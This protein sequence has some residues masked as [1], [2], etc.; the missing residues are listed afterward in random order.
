MSGLKKIFLLLVLLFAA[1]NLAY[2]AVV[3]IADTPFSS[4][5]LSSGTGGD[6]PHIS[7]GVGGVNCASDAVNS[8]AECNTFLGIDDAQATP[9]DGN[10]YNCSCPAAYSETCTIGAGLPCK[11]KFKSCSQEQSCS[12]VIDSYYGAGTEVKDEGECRT[13]QGTEYYKSPLCT[14]SAGDIKA[15]CIFP[16]CTDLQTNTWREYN[17]P[18]QPDVI[19][20]GGV[21]STGS[22][23]KDGV[24]Y[25]PWFCD[26]T[27]YTTEEEPT[28]PEMS[29]T[30]SCTL[31]KKTKYKP[32]CVI[33]TCDAVKADAQFNGHGVVVTTET[34]CKANQGRSFW[35]AIECM[36]GS[37]K[38][39]FCAYPKCDN[40]LIES[41]TFTATAIDADKTASGGVVEGR[42]VDGNTDKY[43]WY[44]QTNYSELPPQSCTNPQM[45]PVECPLEKVLKYKNECEFPLCEETD[46]TINNNV[47]A[48][49]VCPDGTTNDFSCR[50]KAADTTAL[51]VCQCNTEIYPFSPEE[52]CD[53]AEEKDPADTR[54][55]MPVR[56]MKTNSLTNP[57]TTSYCEWD[58]QTALNRDTG[59]T[60]TYE[61]KKIRYKRCLPA[62]PVEAAGKLSYMK[63]TCSDGTVLVNCAAGNQAGISAYYCACPKDFDGNDLYHTTCPT[64]TYGG[65]RTCQ[66]G[67]NVKKFE[68]CLPKCD[69]SAPR[70]IADN[71]TEDK[72]EGIAQ[73]SAGDSLG[74][75]V[76][77][78]KSGDAYTSASVCNYETNMYC[79]KKDTTLDSSSC[80]QEFVALSDNGEFS[81]S[82][83][84]ASSTN[85]DKQ[86]CIISSGK[87]AASWQCG[88]YQYYTDEEC[89]EIYGADYRGAGKKC[90]FDLADDGT[91]AVVK[92]ESC[93]LPCPG[94]PYTLKPTSE[95]CNLT[96]STTTYT[97]KAEACFDVESAGQK[98]VC[99]CPD[100]FITLN[101]YCAENHSGDD[102]CLDKYIGQGVACEYDLADA[103]ENT[104]PVKLKKYF[105]NNFGELCLPGIKTET[106]PAT[107]STVCNFGT[108]TN[109]YE[110]CYDTKG[111][112]KAGCKCPAS[113]KTV[114]EH[115]KE[116]NAEQED[117]DKCIAET[118]G[119]GVV[120]E[121]DAVNPYQ[122]GSGFLKKYSSFAPYC[123]ESTERPVS[124][125]ET[126]TLNGQELSAKGSKCYRKGNTTKPYYL[127][128]CPASYISECTE[129]DSGLIPAGKV[130]TF[131]S[132]TS[133]KYEGCFKQCSN[134]ALTPVVGTSD[135]CPM[136][137]GVNADTEE[138][139][140]K[141][142]DTAASYACRCPASQNYKTL[143]R[144]CQ[145]IAPAAD[146]SQEAATARCLN[147]YVGVG[148]PCTFDID[149]NGVSVDKYKSFDR[150]CPTDRP[151]FYTKEECTGGSV[152]GVYEGTCHVKAGD[153]QERV[154][155]TCPTS[156]VTACT[157]G[158]AGTDADGNP[159]STQIPDPDKEPSGQICNFEGDTRIK[160]QGCYT[161]C[162][163]I[164]SKGV[165]YMSD[166][167]ASAV[168][169]TNSLGDGAYFGVNNT[170]EQCS[171]NHVLSNPCYC[172]DTFVACETTKNQRPADN[173][174]ACTISGET[175]YSECSNN[176]CETESPTLAWIEGITE[177]DDRTADA[178]CQASY[179]SGAVGKKCGENKV[180]CT[181]NAR[182][183]T[184]TCDYPYDK[185]D[186]SKVQWC[187]YSTSGGLMK[188]G[189]D[190][191]KLGECKVKP[192]MALCG[193]HILDSSGN[194]QTG[195]TINI[196]STEGQ[197][198][199]QYGPGAKTQLCEYE[200]DSNKRA[201]NCYYNPSDFTFTE[202]NCP[203]RHVLDGG[204]VVKNGTKY[205]ANCNCH[206]AYK[207]HKF[208]CAGMLSGGACTQQ[209]TASMVGNDDSLAGQVGNSLAFYPYCQCT[210]DYKFECDGERNVGVGTACNGKYTECKCQPDELPENWADNYYGCPGGK[211]P[212]GV[213]KPNGCGG[214]YYQCTVTQCTW[215]HTQKCESP[216]IG[217]DPCQDNLGNIGGYKSC[218]CPSGYN[219]CAEGKVGQGEPC[220]LNGQYYY[221]S[222]GDSAECVHGE[223]KTCLGEFQVGVNPCVKNGITYFQY[224]TC[225]QGYDKLCSDEAKVGEGASCK[226]DGK[227]YYSKC[228]AP[229][230]SCTAE[231]KEA[232]DS[233]QEKYDPCVNSDMK[234]MYKCK[235]PTNYKSCPNG[236]ADGTPSC[237]DSNGTVYA[238]CAVSNT[239]NYEQ[240]KN[241]KVCTS[242]QKGVGGSCVDSIVDSS[243]N[244]TDIIKYADCEDTDQC[245]VN[246][247]QYTCMGYDQSN[248]GD[249]FCTDDKGNRLYKECKC[250]TDWI[251][252]PG[253]NNTKG[254]ACTPQLENGST[255]TTV[256]KS[257]TCDEFRF[258]Y[259]CAASETGNKGVIP[260]SSKSCQPRTYKD[261]TEYGYEEGSTLYESCDCTAGYTQTCKGNGQVGNESDYCE[262]VPGSGNK[263]YKSC[264]CDSKYS[265]TC[266]LDAS[267]PGMS[268]PA[269]PLKACIAVDD[270][271]VEAAPKYTACECGKYYDLTCSDG[272]T[273]GSDTDFC[274][275]ADGAVDKTYYRKCSCNPDIYV[276]TCSAETNGKGAEVSKVGTD[277]VCVEKLSA[278]NGLGDQGAI[279]K[280][281][282]S[283]CTCKTNYKYSCVKGVSN[284]N[285]AVLN[286]NGY[287]SETFNEES[288][289]ENKYA[290]PSDEFCSKTTGGN[291]FYQ[292][293]SCKD[294][295][296]YK[297]CN[298]GSG[299]TE[300]HA[301]KA[302][303]VNNY[304]LAV[305]ANGNVSKMYRE[306]DCQCKPKDLTAEELAVSPAW[307][308]TTLIS[309]V[310]Q[311]NNGIFR[312]MVAEKCKDRDNFDLL[313]KGCNTIY[314]RCVF[315]PNV[316]PYSQSN[317][318]SLAPSGSAQYVPQGD[319]DTKTTKIGSL[320]MY[321][322]C[323]CDASYKFTESGSTSCEKFYEASSTGD[324]G[325]SVGCQ[326]QT[327]DTSWI[328]TGCTTAGIDNE[329]KPAISLVVLDESSLCIT[330]ETH[331]KKYSRCK[332]RPAGT[333]HGNACFTYQY[334][335]EG[336]DMI[337]ITY[338][339]K[340]DEPNTRYPETIYYNGGKA[341]NDCQCKI[342][343][344]TSKTQQ[345]G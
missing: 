237:T 315:D 234:I 142:G 19:A 123:P 81:S 192:V 23:W 327:S 236:A 37:T 215:Q 266:A 289:T 145:T 258:R 180:Q 134:T 200:N 58:Y 333:R 254:T 45:R 320:T 179:G 277:D 291:K 210:A 155:C 284:L 152:K 323:D 311:Y 141:T 328:Y 166:D 153:T 16:L 66:E 309:D 149:T 295:Y 101:Q 54:V 297:D 62:C 336:D 345:C 7:T 173:A 29:T 88:C 246:G 280:E 104:T 11:G 48:S 249:D 319:K 199:S 298:F 209:V 242:S 162:D 222:C 271:G 80:T 334:V 95:A 171:K 44:C 170:G 214:K 70:K 106:I 136:V 133:P 245:R 160:Y 211:Q 40:E 261:G 196:T 94:A 137:N 331:E 3:N 5:S 232:C 201:F 322:K 287:T 290:F 285:N 79:C 229:S 42:C 83:T 151:L 314:F 223:T 278:G 75:W 294:E 12:D 124:E 55:W 109:N 193:K 28:C 30:E 63:Q 318:P 203:V 1:A 31:E 293:C 212:T 61:S 32:A 135:A 241:Y 89:S 4:R 176:K 102:K 24:R 8:P 148:T 161:K 119:E 73:G 103:P 172:D 154:L 321:K 256:Y 338:T 205:Y 64:G 98:Y 67:G 262:K 281:Y 156:Y 46:R 190:H 308:Q 138:C 270:G 97:A 132:L 120:C 292:S 27:V 213:T 183:F 194:Q 310:S 276:E 68:F 279:R 17:N 34:A 41:K 163:T 302:D 57:D 329:N 274:K 337:C 50:L 343:K 226:L 243:G 233:N 127:C 59:K 147:E 181:C 47:P 10:K 144:F 35:K 268:A 304:C 14:N 221:Q 82:C 158:S 110:S 197:C 146:E 195:Y 265:L 224:C 91:T 189:V 99:H 227:E 128:S 52:G 21:M 344:M 105:R 86:L 140:L 15:A 253:K 77:A 252:C 39:V 131:E 9:C 267:N 51:K 2:A 107:G 90:E 288:Y 231:H 228:V 240:K 49:S 235:C 257:C 325:E 22:C 78:T 283:G 251:P 326:K 185:P 191:F 18:S 342:G 255:G 330:R 114:E 247:Y 317:C 216:L 182:E 167:D 299:S 260:A 230:N 207:Q 112:L 25:A 202:S 6:S 306:E 56:D 305:A 184:E 313:D 36:D 178:I 263:L 74:K 208:N 71:P 341:Q 239:C 108:T 324:M 126:C 113:Y 33:P 187:K 286:A 122:S 13:I 219:L 204:Y 111:D 225:S 275:I 312:Q 340:P 117:I 238:E 220:I 129:A 250:P 301:V 20:A 174:K 115:C 159:I 339:Y 217:I 303:S 84:P 269:D 188:N 38:R 259:E 316:Y 300:D 143:Q 139:Y 186:K 26:S 296:K 92:Y 96:E 282:Y 69:T 130:C 273:T 93:S 43:V 248:L 168:E 272:K 150:I 169:C 87:S 165:Q 65:G 332:C 244:T 164:K 116:I 335:N 175:F 76:C 72:C 206:P 264:T 100:N 157:K 53:D 307:E 198:T 60:Q 85:Y 118:S 125:T 177:E 121:F 218:K